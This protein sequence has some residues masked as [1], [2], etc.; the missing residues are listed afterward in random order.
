MIGQTSGRRT[1]GPTPLDHHKA[2]TRSPP[3][4]RRCHRSKSAVC[5]RGAATVSCYYPHAPLLFTP[6]D[7]GRIGPNT[8][9]NVIMFL[10]AGRLPSLTPGEV[11]SRGSQN[12]IIAGTC[13]PCSERWCLSSLDPVLVLGCR[14]SRAEAVEA[15]T[16]SKVNLCVRPTVATCHGSYSFGTGALPERHR[17]PTSVAGVGSNSRAPHPSQGA[18][19]AD[20]TAPPPGGFHQLTS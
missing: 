16:L 9:Q 4:R 14:G 12:Q 20:R 6:I 7:T 2:T 18:A 11:R 8:A 1:N 17:G 10:C 3:A 19:A 15:P 5:M 13:E